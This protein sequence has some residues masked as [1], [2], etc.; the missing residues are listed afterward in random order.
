MRLYRARLEYVER[1][2]P[3][4]FRWGL[5]A[6]GLGRDAEP[7]QFYMVRVGEGYDP[8]LR[9]PFAL[10]R[11]GLRRGRRGRKSDG[12]EIL[13]QVVGRGTQALAQ[14][15]KGDVIDLFGPLGRGWGRP[16]G[17]KP[18]LVAGGVGVAS[19]VCLAQEMPLGL[20][21]GAVAFIGAK[22]RERL[23]CV[24]DLEEMG[25]TVHTSVER[26]EGPFRGTVLE[27]L[28][29][30]WLE[31][32]HRSPFL[33]VCG[34][35]AMVRA[36]AQWAEGQGVPCQVSLESSMGCGTGVC[37]GCAVKARSGYLRVCKDGPVFD[38][39]EIDWGA[40]DVG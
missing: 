8:L 29:A 16:S 23:W 6:Q 39:T 15:G 37:L 36:V 33:F 35:K 26:G 34:P 20:R 17:G 10:H 38:A 2:H 7:G 13:F 5:A 18:V 21:R 9:R 27:L 24:D 4:L 14:K 1:L 19:L 25:L 28:E 22:S 11:K 30:H 31:I 32:A 40:L 12:G 3:E